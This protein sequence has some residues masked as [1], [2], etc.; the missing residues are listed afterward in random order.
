[1]ILVHLSTKC[2]S[3]S[4]LKNSIISIS[5]RFQS[6]STAV[7]SWCHYHQCPVWLIFLKRNLEIQMLSSKFLRT[8]L[9]VKN[10]IPT[11]DGN[12]G[13]YALFNAFKFLGKNLMGKKLVHC[14]ANPK[15][16]WTKRIDLLKFG[17]KE[18]NNFVQHHDN[19][20]RP[21]LNQILP[22]GHSHIFGLHGQ[23][24]VTKQN[25]IDAFM[26][27]IGNSIYTEEFDRQDREKLDKDFYL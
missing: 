16:A 13:Y 15:T 4:Y 5:P 3:W 20:I 7:L 18:F 12:C 9:A 10:H 1:M 22:D 2:W 24:L 14:A 6:K 21:K 25:K 19:S 11:G 17:L 8:I 26:A 23:N 27:T